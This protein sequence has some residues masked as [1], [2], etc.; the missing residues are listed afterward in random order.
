MPAS[1]LVLLSLSKKLDRKK[2]L[3]QSEK[4]YAFSLLRSIAGVGANVSS[5]L[6]EMS[7]ER[8][9]TM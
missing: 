2:H 1:S 6:F 3:A 8:I 7:V 9:I 4:P 5:T